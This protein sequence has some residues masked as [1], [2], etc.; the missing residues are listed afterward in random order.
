MSNILKSGM[1][2]L[3]Q[4]MLLHASETIVYSRGNDSVEV[5]AVL[6]KKLLKID[7]G[8]GG[9]RIEVTDLDV[10]VAAD[11]L[12]LA[13]ERV[14]PQRG[15]LV[16]LTT[17]YDTQTFEVLPIGSEPAWRWSDPFQSMFRIHAKHI[18]T[19]QFYS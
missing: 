19:D 17:D 4:Q 2:Y 1:A 10:L 13:S 9:F 3:T 7:D 18:D 12:V 5:Q 15:D 11:D 16:L 8:Q 6:G 14:T